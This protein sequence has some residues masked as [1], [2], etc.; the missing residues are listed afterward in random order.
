MSLAELRAALSDPAAYPEATAT[1]ETRE[2]HI[3]LVFLTDR[4]AY[5]IKKPVNLG[6]VDYGTEKRRHAMCQREI[7]LNQRLSENV[8]LGV[9]AIVRDGS[10]LRVG[11]KGKVI[12]HA[13]RMLRLPDDRALGVLLNQ[14]ESV[15]IETLGHRIARFHSGHGLP[16]TGE[17]YGDLDHVRADWMEN[18]AQTKSWIGE[19]VSA[20]DHE[21]IRHSIESFLERHAMWF[22]E[23]IADNRIRDCHGDLR[24]EHVYWIDDEFQIIDCIEFNQRFRCIDGASEVAFLAMDLARLGHHRAAD[25][26]V[27]G[28]VAESNDLRLYRLLDFYRCYRAFV[29]AKVCGFRSTSA[30]G[31]RRKKICADAK[32]FFLLANSYAENLDRP[33]V[34]MMTGLIGTGK[35]T[36]A[37]AVAAALDIRLYSSDCLRKERAGL[38]PQ[39]PQRVEFGTG[40]YSKASS[41]DT[42]VALL[43]FARQAL[44]AGASVVLDAAYP[45]NEDRLGV[46]DLARKLGAKCH[47]IQCIAPDEI[48]HRRLQERN[49]HIGVISDGRWSL[50]PQFKRSYEPVVDLPNTMIIRLNTTQ[51]IERNVQQALWMI[52]RT[53]TN[54]KSWCVPGSKTCRASRVFLVD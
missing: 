37:Q 30:N 10:T 24:A 13:V 52:R 19:L 48:I 33:V 51:G 28:Y 43:D 53:D 49:H 41:A 18:F 12:E 31:P 26:F 47:I 20:A 27:R 32:S 42:Y 3:S 45:R 1:V 11:G 14:G 23:R 54:A 7:S 6:F 39:I 35:S 8:Y 36:L 15:P 21:L 22:A 16:D 40:I 9:D 4:H 2:T 38:D 17:H 50:F 44:E 34:I 5:K 25:R 29:R 46:A